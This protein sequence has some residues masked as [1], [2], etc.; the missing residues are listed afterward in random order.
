MRLLSVLRL[1]VLVA[2]SALVILA[3]R[4]PAQEEES[5]GI[6]Q[7]QVTGDDIA[8]ATTMTSNIRYHLFLA[9]TA[10]ASTALES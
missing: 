2:V 10:A 3:G 7:L 8:A 5:A 6:A 1:V 9:R 4:A